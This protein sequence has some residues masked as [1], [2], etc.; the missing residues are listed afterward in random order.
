MLVD[1]VQCG[2]RYPTSHA[3]RDPSSP[4]QYFHQSSVVTSPYSPDKDHQSLRGFLIGS[5]ECVRDCKFCCK[6]CR[7]LGELRKQN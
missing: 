3:G 2:K 6:H 7:C 1:H 5:L 4:Y